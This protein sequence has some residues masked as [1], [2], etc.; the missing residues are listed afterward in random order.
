MDVNC[1]ISGDISYIFIISISDLKQHTSA[2]TNRCQIGNHKS[3]GSCVMRQNA[4]ENQKIEK[5]NN[6][7]G[8]YVVGN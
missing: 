3:Q 7:A 8:S 2:S 1:E 4:R 5:K 6:V